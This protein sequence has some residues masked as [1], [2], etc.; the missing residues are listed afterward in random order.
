MI[1]F[2]STGAT[3]KPKSLHV[4]VHSHFMNT[5]LKQRYW[6]KKKLVYY[7]LCGQLTTIVNGTVTINV[8]LSFRTTVSHSVCF[9]HTT[10]YDI[11]GA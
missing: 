8:K 2:M 4:H 3:S 11:P 7:S 9:L 1:H 5:K 6:K 10:P